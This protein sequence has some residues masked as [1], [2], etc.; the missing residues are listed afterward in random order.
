MEDVFHSFGADLG[1]F[2]KPFVSDFRAESVLVT[3]GIAE[4]WGRFSN[5]LRYSL[6]VPVLKGTPG[7]RAALF[8]AAAL[9]S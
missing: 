8:G 7:N 9:Y 4:S 1:M 2:L 3:G 5:S 6:P